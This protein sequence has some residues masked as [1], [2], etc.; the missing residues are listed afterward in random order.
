MKTKKINHEDEYQLNYPN[1]SLFQ[2]IEQTALKYPTNIIYDFYG[3]KSTYKNFIKEVNECAKSLKALGIK[4]NDKVTICMP[5]CPQAIIAFYAINLIGAIASMVHPLSSE[6]EI[7][8]YLNSSESVLAIT[9]DM[10]YQKFENIKDETKLKKIVVS[11]I[12]DKMPLIPAIGYYVMKGH[13]IKPINNSDV[14]HWSEFIKMGNDYLGEYRLDKKDIDP[15]VIL[16]SGGTTGDPKG[17]LLSNLNFNALAMQS[18]I[19]SDCM[20]PGDSMLG[21]MPIFHGFGLGVCIHTIFYM[22][23]KCILIP[24]FNAKKFDELFKKYKP[25]FIVGVPTLF[26][27]LT[28]NKKMK[29]VD[30][31]YLKCVIS[32]GDSLSPPLKKKIDEFLKEH[33]ANIQ[34]REGYGM[35]ESVS[36]TCLTPKET[37]KEGSIGVPYPDMIFKIVYP[38]TQEEV[39]INEQGEICIS[40]PTVMLGYLNSP[41]ETVLALQT[42]KDGRTWLHT[43]DLGSMDKDGFVYFHQRLKRMIISS[44][45]NIYP[46]YIENV[47][48]NHPDVLASTVIGVKDEYKGQKIK[49]FVILKDD[50]EDT[51]EVRKSIYKHCLKNIS[52]YAMPYT[53]E[54]RKS[55]PKTL[56][57]KVAYGELEKESNEQEDDE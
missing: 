31:S 6:G 42:H 56:V 50:I 13:K 5:N 37:A 52:K 14:I 27:A 40:G 11:S 54:Y 16:Y 35:T 12:K 4:E 17:I 10:T 46:H 45:Y 30:L 49:A 19:A 23:C 47:I 15:A 36:A 1:G 3:T 39:P 8:I 25:N 32:G 51:E 2:L 48:E 55:L 43:G 26:E 33:N 29:N 41:K 21:I 20:K 24:Q 9:L 53:F 34:I 18:D 22:G 44:G 38:N 7:K 28:R 57:G